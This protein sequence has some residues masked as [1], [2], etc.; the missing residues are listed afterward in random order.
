[1][2]LEELIASFASLVSSLIA[3]T[4]PISTGT[5]QRD[6]SLLFEEIAER[7]EVYD[8]LIHR[9]YDQER[10]AEL[11]YY[12]EDVSFSALFPA[13]DERTEKNFCESF[14]RSC[15][16]NLGL[17]MAVTFMLGLLAVGLV[18][19]D[20]NTTNACIEWMHNNFT[21]PSNVRL[22][23]IVG[24]SVTLLPLY[25]WFPACMIMLWGFKQFR[26][27]YLL[28][29]FACQSVTLS[30]VMAYKIL[31]FDNTR[32]T[33]VDYRYVYRITGVNVSI[34]NRAYLTLFFVKL[35]SDQF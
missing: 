5:Q 17:V 32:T 13:Y 7:E 21:V 8:G 29:L 26:K 31:A 23:R 33:N 1:M 6:C 10:P 34:T 22:M 25:A 4:P 27:N 2:I 20:L 24:M 14:L 3:Q 28:R 35:F 16:A 9:E 15:K 18:F 11:P 12:E 19:V 30:L